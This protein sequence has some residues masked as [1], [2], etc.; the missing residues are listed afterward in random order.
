MTAHERTT[1]SQL[2]QAWTRQHEIEIAR[3]LGNEPNKDSE[4][5]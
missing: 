1:F 2:A 5:A 3:I 4:A